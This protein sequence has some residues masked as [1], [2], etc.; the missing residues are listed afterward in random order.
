MKAYRLVLFLT[1]ECD[2]NCFYCDIGQI[3]NQQKPQKDL[4]YKYFPMVN[5]LDELFPVFT[6]TGGEP[7]LIPK[8]II[9]YIFEEVC[10]CHKI[11]VNTNGLFIEKGYLDKYYD[12][13]DWVGY[14]PNIEVKEDI[15][16][17][18]C[19]EKVQLFQPVHAK[20]FKDVPDKVKRYPK[21]KFNLI[22]F[23]QKGEF[24]GDYEYIL[25]NHEALQ[26]QKS[27]SEFPN[28]LPDTLDML[29]K[30]FMS[31]DMVKNDY[32]IAC[33]NS[34][35]HPTIDFVKGQILRCPISRM[36]TDKVDLTEENMKKMM[37]FNLFKDAGYDIGCTQCND[38]FRYFDTFFPNHM[39]R[40]RSK[41]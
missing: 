35:I 39:E 24:P 6:I 40:N 13:I 28:V 5:G 30:T 22:P 3:K 4:I 34:Q 2:K 41:F 26:L 12:K 21:Q 36:H 17:D 18:I 11:R 37:E 19:D 10:D 9:E 32:R 38:C 31:G 15:P 20:N 14:H 8:D 16:L 27:V 23:L 33:G 25:S 7:G 1:E 29:T